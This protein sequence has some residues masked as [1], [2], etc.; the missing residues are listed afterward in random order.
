MFYIL[1]M[2]ILGTD[3][4]DILIILWF[5]SFAESSADYVT[6]FGHIGA[7]RIKMVF[8]SLCNK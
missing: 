4:M 1:N 8:Y 6:Q 3:A 7:S 2:S 5:I